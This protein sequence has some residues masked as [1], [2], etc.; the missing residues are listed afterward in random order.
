VNFWALKK[1]MS[2]NFFKERVL[3]QK[4]SIA[5]IKKI[6]KWNKVFCVVPFIRSV[7][8]NGTLAMKNSNQKSDWDVLIITKK[9]RIWIG[10]FFLSLILSFLGKRRVGKR[11]KNEFCLNHY[12][13]EDGLILEE[14]GIFIASLISFSFWIIGEENLSGK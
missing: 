11:V 9:N 8:V 10:R 4:I 7:I 2:E 5:K 12:L 1:G 13:T 3:K 6:R 14:Q